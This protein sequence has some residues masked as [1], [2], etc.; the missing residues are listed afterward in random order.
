M[1]RLS[2]RRYH[3]PRRRAFSLFEAVISSLLVGTLMVSATRAVSSSILS[4]RRMADRSK[5]AWLAD[6]LVAELHQQSYMEPGATSSTLGRETGETSDSRVTYDDVDDYVGFSESPPKD[7][8]GTTLTNLIGW[9]RS[10]SVQWVSLNDI[11][12]VSGSETG[13]KKATVT[14]SFN[15]QLVLTRIIIRTKGG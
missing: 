8:D 6:A 14:V 2:N 11:A 3:Q 9:Q 15:N 5:A 13:V 7:K 1:N 4:Q 10:V 12:A